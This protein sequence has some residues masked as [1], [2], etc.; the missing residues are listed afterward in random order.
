MFMKTKTFTHF[1]MAL[2]TFLFLALTVQAQTTISVA[3]TDSTDVEESLVDGEMYWNSSDLELG[4]DGVPQ[5]VGLQFKN[6]D[7]PNGAAITEAYIQFTCD[8]VNDAEDAIILE[9]FGE[10]AD[11][12]DTLKWGSSNPYNISTREKTTAVVEWSPPPWETVG[13][14]AD[15]QKTADISSIITEIVGRAGWAPGNA[16][17]VMIQAK[18]T[19][20]LFAR[21]AESGYSPDDAAVLH[22]TYESSEPS[23]TL[24]VIWEPGFESDTVFTGIRENGDLIWRDW[25]NTSIN[26]DPQYVF[27]GNRSMKSGP[28]SGGRNQYTSGWT[29][30]T[31]ISLFAWATIDDVGPRTQHA[32]IGFREYITGH[33]EN[34]EVDSRIDGETTINEPGVWVRLR[35]CMT[36]SEETEDVLIFFW[37]SADE[38]PGP[39]IYIDDFEF[40]FGDS[41]TV[42]TRVDPIEYNGSSVNVY[43]NPTTGPVQ[44]SIGNDVVGAS[45]IKIFDVTGKVISRVDNLN[46]LEEVSVDLSSAP[47]GI[48]IGMLRS[49]S[50]A[51]TFKILKRQ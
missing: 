36:L 25:D 33:I 34:Q 24:P 31:T 29:A 9:I 49:E 40:K 39:S 30:G 17:L 8:E 5:V 47:A 16:L 6:I 45:S 38:D 22:V 21:W 18:D 27:S 2:S 51:H 4:R 50:K 11:N 19:S 15:S 44:I 37:N 26:E 46:G 10:A 32:Y 41:C 42:D 1:L 23:A 14:A 20:N 12:S 7:I 48:Y 43:P 35:A 28:L 13:A 3:V